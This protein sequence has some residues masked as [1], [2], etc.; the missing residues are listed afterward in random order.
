MIYQV[1]HNRTSWFL[2][3]NLLDVIALEK[4]GC[5]VEISK[6][7]TNNGLFKLWK[8]KELMEQIPSMESF[9][10]FRKKNDPA[11]FS[12][13]DSTLGIRYTIEPT[14]RE[15]GYNL[16]REDRNDLTPKQQ[17]MNMMPKNKIKGVY[18]VHRPPHGFPV[19]ELFY[20]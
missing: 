15:L 13:Q 12:S 7:N 10:S 1:R 6:V 11:R 2:S 16:T 5:T 17:A 19:L 20:K 14:M 3:G 18:H 9:A 4:M 8:L